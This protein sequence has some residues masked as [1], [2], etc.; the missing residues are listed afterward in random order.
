MT[1][2]V[3]SYHDLE[4]KSV[5]ISGGGSGIGAALV[6]GFLEQGSKVGFV[7]KVDSVELC[8]QLEQET[9]AR[10]HFVKCD[11][12]DIPAFRDAISNCADANGDISVLVNNAAW[13]N[14]QGL[15][16][17]KVEDFDHMMQV[18][19]RHHFFAIQSVAPAMA[20]MGSGSIINYSSTSYMIGIAGMSAYIATK[21][22]I[23]GMTRSL[24]REL[25]PD[26]I[27]VNAVMPGWVFTERQQELWATP[28]SVAAHIDRQ[29]LQEKMTTQDM[30]SPTLFLASGA[31]TMMTGQALVVD[32]GVVVSG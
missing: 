29:C 26:N 9:G 30:V 17:L 12:L 21:S 7:D 22:A 20:N 6:R 8:E 32:A 31:S 5:F 11:V 23:T 15:H 4:G 28:E 24:A 2:P 27:R 3:A 18:N 25:G 13:D 1:Q 19:L 14:R 16:E 10:P